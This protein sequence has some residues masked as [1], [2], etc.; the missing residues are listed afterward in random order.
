M[1]ARIIHQVLTL[2]L[3]RVLLPRDFGVLAM[4]T[5]ATGFLGLFRRV[6]TD[7]AVI[8]RRDVDEEYLSTVFWTNLAWGVVIFAIAYAS[9]DL[10]GVVLKEPVVG[11]LTAVLSIQFI[12]TAFSATHV[13]LMSRR[14]DYRTQ[15]LIDMASTVVGGV[16]GIGMAYAGMGVWSLVGQ[17][18]GMTTSA[19]VAYYCTAGWKPRRLF[20]W[21]RFLELWSFSAPLLVSR[22][23]VYLSTSA[24]TFLIGRHLGSGVLG[25]YALGSKGFNALLVDVLAPV[26][27]VMVSAFSRLQADASLLKHAFIVATR[28]VTMVSL[29][30]MVGLSLIAAPLI[31][32][33]FGARWLPAAPAMSLLA[34]TGAF[35]VIG[36]L[37]WSG[38]YAVGR[39]DLQ[40]RWSF[41]AVLMYPAAFAVGLRWGIVGVAAGSLVVTIM[42]A[43]VLYAFV[44]R[45]L[46]ATMREV[47]RAVRPSIVGCAAMAVG[48]MPAS[49]A[50]ESAG[51]P[52]I[53]VLVLVVALGG[54]V[55]GAV[56]WSLDRE[57]VLQLVRLGRESF[58]ARIERRPKEKDRVDAHPKHP[59]VVEEPDV[60]VP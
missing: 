50:L 53:V 42:L 18:L 20:S 55:Y 46:R 51:L 6:G 39:T 32:V 37:A 22:L 40:M 38:L 8:Q 36:G 35:D 10:V 45:V 52:K 28:L 3:V 2:I 43:P 47:W 14:L 41:L 57:G 12:V 59:I 24:D 5:M 16:V 56:M 1:I 58:L 15:A 49:W 31:E 11:P 7:L 44:A 13:A 54:L 60:G 33:L 4:A 30:M 19:A 17:G 21:A 29:P 25:F 27:Q 26:N 48:V 34:L 23:F 9:S